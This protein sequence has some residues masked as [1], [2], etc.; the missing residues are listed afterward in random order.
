MSKR[1]IS[2]AF[3]YFPNRLLQVH[4]FQDNSLFGICRGTFSSHIERLK[5][6]KFI[7]GET[8]QW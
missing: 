7:E 4:K 6:K 5:N 1:R 3:V 2:I 8:H